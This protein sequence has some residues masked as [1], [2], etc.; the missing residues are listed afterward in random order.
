MTRTK[1]ILL[2]C[3]VAAFAAGT[4]AGL[5]AGKSQPRPHDRSWLMA[6]LSLTTQQREQM[7]KIWSE[8]MDA[9]VTQYGEQRRAIAG[10][11]DKAIAALLTQEQQ[12]KYEQILRECNQKLAEL[13]E[14]RKHAFEQAVEQT[15]QILTPDQGKQYDELI[16]RQRD[17]GFGGPGRTPPWGTGSRPR[18]GGP[19]NMP[20]SNEQ[21]APRGEE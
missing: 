16:K 1:V 8:A 10:E 12:P 5:V 9:S 15:K 3:F 4:T 17:R 21:H 20:T 2:V 11:R 14:Q 18:H 7:R 19:R 6:Q 13:S